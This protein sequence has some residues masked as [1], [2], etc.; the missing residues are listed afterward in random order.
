MEAQSQAALS[1]ERDHP[2][3]QPAPHTR[4][5]VDTCH[6]MYARIRLGIYPRRQ[7]E[8]AAGIALLG[9]PT[10]NAS[11]VKCV[12]ASRRART[13]SWT[14]TASERSQ[15][16]HAEQ[17]TMKNLITQCYTHGI[18]PKCKAN[19]YSIPKPGSCWKC[20][21]LISQNKIAVHQ[22]MTNVVIIIHILHSVLGQVDEQEAFKWTLS[23]LTE[24]KTCGTCC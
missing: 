21:F 6:W 12:S 1:L 10:H 8:G 9:T 5:R 13:V 16:M 3:P 20:V 15:H 22:N 18:L 7:R 19:L 14:F 17:W 24:V 2:L 11:S 23:C 4:N